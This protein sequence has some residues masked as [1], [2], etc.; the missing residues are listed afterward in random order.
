MKTKIKVKIGFFSVLML[1]VIFV[2]SSSYLPALILSVAIHECGHVAAARICGI[3]LSELNLGIFGAALTPSDSI[4]SYKKEVLLCLGGPAFNFIS[5]FLYHSITKNTDSLFIVSS[6]SLGILNLLPIKGFDGGRIC[7]AMLCII[8]GPQKSTGI[9]NLISFFC[10]FG[11]WTISVYLLIKASA[12]LS[13]FVF[14][15]SMFVKIF[16]PDA[17]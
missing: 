11:T 6:L 12:S 4:Y 3:R 16:I 9:I 5:A 14:S 8:L 7:E 15:A 17:T 1:S 13:L 10:L 2:T